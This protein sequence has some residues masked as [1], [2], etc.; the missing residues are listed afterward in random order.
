MFG[1]AKR[2]ATSPTTHVSP[3]EAQTLVERGEAILVDV[4]EDAEWSAGH[5]PGA[6]HVPL[7]RFEA[8][9]GRVPP[10]KRVILYCLSGG[11]S[12][13]A[14]SLCARMGLRIDT[15]VAGG[16]GAWRAAGLPVV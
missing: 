6:F 4:R 9:I 11:R 15:H 1:I 7:S 5:V 12:G 3:R 14:L 8:E 16:I 13:R 10:T 2:A